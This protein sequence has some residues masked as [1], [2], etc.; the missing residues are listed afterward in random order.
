MTNIM[1]SKQNT[2]QEL[3]RSQNQTIML[4]SETHLTNKYNFTIPGF[5]KRM[6][7]K[8]FSLETDYV[9]LSLTNTQKT[10]YMQARSYSTIQI[11]NNK[12][13]IWRIF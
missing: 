13:Q 10:M 2:M 4:I 1:T 11:Y 12:G 3:L 5:V 6:L 8:A 9:T 7:V